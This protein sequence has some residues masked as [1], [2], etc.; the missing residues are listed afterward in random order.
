MATTED[1]A[2]GSDSHLRQLDKNAAAFV[3]G[4]TGTGGVYT[5]SATGSNSVSS[6]SWDA[7]TQTLTQTSLAANK[8]VRGTSV[9]DVIHGL[10]G[11]R[12]FALDGD[13]TLYGAGGNDSLYGGSGTDLLVGGAGGNSFYVNSTTTT[14][15]DTAGSDDTAWSTVSFTLPANVDTLHLFGEGLTGKANDQGDTLF[16]DGTFATTLIGGT[17]VDY[18]VGGA[19]D[20][21]IK[22]GGGLDLMYGGTGSDRFVFK[23]VTDAPSGLNRTTIGDFTE[24][25]D[26]I[27]LSAIKT[28]GTNPGQ[29]LTF[30]GTGA[31]SDQA[32]QVRQ[33]TSGSN[34][35]VAGDVN[36]DG[37][38]EFEIQLNGGMTLN[39]NDFAFSSVACFRGGTRILTSNGRIVRRN[40]HDR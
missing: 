2:T 10:A 40:P 38:A 12:L 22:G 21:V 39:S 30:I 35:I 19:G 17:G 25:T 36:G 7:T 15:D 27:D 33:F 4:A 32:G 6:W 13:D 37:T 11:D 20:D 14:I 28:T 18:I 3:Y 24:G 31:F 5:A 16:G 34:T 26:K 23:S 9:N 1:A 29:D 8:T